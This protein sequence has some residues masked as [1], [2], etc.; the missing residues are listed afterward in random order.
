MYP[1][2]CWTVPKED[3]PVCLEF[4]VSWK[5]LRANYPGLF[6]HDMP[7]AHRHQPRAGWRKITIGFS[8]LVQL[9]VLTGPCALEPRIVM[10]WD[11]LGDVVDM[12]AER[13]CWLKREGLMEWSE[14][15]DDE[16]EEYGEIDPED[17]NSGD[18]DTSDEENS[19]EDE[20]TPEDEGTSE[21]EETSEDEDA[22]EDVDDSDA[23]KDDEDDE[24]QSANDNEEDGEEGIEE[25]KVYT[26][27]R[28]RGRMVFVS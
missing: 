28:R 26:M 1:F 24:E 17:C 11:T 14:S 18:E 12:M 6:E 27:V 22:W 10:E 4:E 15:E 25:R 19:S 16:E 7:C 20:G 5:W 21:D 13:L 23:E 8:F 3:E 9:D 2:R